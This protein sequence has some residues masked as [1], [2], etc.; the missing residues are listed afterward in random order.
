MLIALALL[1]YAAILIFLAINQ[2]AMVFQV[3][4]WHGEVPAGYQE[5]SYET[6]DGLALTAGFA[7]PDQGMPTVLFFH[8][9]ATNWT[10]SP[11]A[12]DFL[13]EAGYGVLAAEY[14]GYRGNPGEPTEADMA[15]DARAA[16][17]WLM[18]R[19]QLPADTIIIG[20]S[21]GSVPSTQLAGFVEPA[22]LLLISPIGDMKQIAGDIYWWL[23]ISLLLQ[24]SYDNISRMPAISAPTKIFHGEADRL[25]NV[26]QARQLQAASRSA[27]LMTFAQ[28]GHMAVLEEDVQ[29]AQLDYIAGLADRPF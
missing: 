4:D 26:D 1:L 17:D 28:H 7:P 10:S 2:R 21:L 8:G 19:G 23:P 12:T 3:P 20:N 11:H 6:S 22:A 14:R 9:N 25:I 24:D 15:T 13:R 18:A 5:V 29:Q 16:W 27:Q